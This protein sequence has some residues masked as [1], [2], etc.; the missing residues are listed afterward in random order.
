MPLA[1]KNARDVLWLRS[2]ADGLRD[3]ARPP[4]RYS[5][6]HARAMQNQGGAT[7][8]TNAIALSVA[9]RL[10]SQAARFVHFGDPLPLLYEEED[11]H[12][13]S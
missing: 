3:S 1:R 6:K 8:R 7:A 10:E 13:D 12:A 11:I 4:R 2:Q 5:A 9:Q